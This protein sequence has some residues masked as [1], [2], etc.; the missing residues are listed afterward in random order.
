M[1]YGLLQNNSITRASVTGSIMQLQCVSDSTSA[2]VG[3]WL[4][5]NG[6]DITSKSD[7]PFM[8]TLGDETDPGYLAVDLTEGYSLTSTDEGVYTC[9]IPDADGID[10]YLHIG[11]Y[12][13][14]FSSKQEL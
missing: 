6:E 10:N 3:N 2:G 9:T 8:I 5:P 14:G 4:A 11:I 1:G 12:R 7:D 13:N